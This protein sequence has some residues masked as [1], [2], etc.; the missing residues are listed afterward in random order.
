MNARGHVV[1]VLTRQNKHRTG[2]EHVDELLSKAKQWL[3]KTVHTFHQL[4]C[5]TYTQKRFVQNEKMS[6]REV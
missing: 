5:T 3:D 6:Y 2:S 4:L 1:Q